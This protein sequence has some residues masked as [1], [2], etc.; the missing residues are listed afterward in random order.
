MAECHFIESFVLRL[1]CGFLISLL[2]DLLL[3]PVLLLQL[4]HPLAVAEA[5]VFTVEHTHSGDLLSS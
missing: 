1:R 3:A 2:L 4:L 5:L